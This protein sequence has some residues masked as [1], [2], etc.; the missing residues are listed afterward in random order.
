MPAIGLAAAIIERRDPDA[1]IGSF[2]ADHVIRHEDEFRDAVREAV[3][4]A[5]TGRIVTI[6]ITPTDPVD[7]VRLHPAGRR[8]WRSRAPPRRGRSPSSSRSPT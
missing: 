4:V 3:A 5:R 6:G 7:G 8:S 2:A 1:V